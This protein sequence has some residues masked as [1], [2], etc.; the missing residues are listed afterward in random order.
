M[1]NTQAH[2]VKTDNDFIQ[3][4]SVA[5]SDMLMV[6][7]CTSTDSRSMHNIEK[8]VLFYTYVRF[9]YFNVMRTNIVYG[10]VIVIAYFEAVKCE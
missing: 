1:R 6:L 5:E 10:Q 4:S 8:V 7:L 2:C 9:W 3:F